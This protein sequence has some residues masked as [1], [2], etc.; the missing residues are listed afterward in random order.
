MITPNQKNHIDSIGRWVLYRLALLLLVL[1]G[2]FCA[3]SMRMLDRRFDSFD[4]E[5]YRQELMRVSAAFD[6]ERLSMALMIGDYARWDD[7]EQFVDDHNADFIRSNFTVESLAYIRITAYVIEDT[8]GLPIS[9]Q[10]LTSDG[11]LVDTPGTLLA[12]L[13]PWLMKEIRSGGVDDTATSLLWLAETP[14][15]FSVAPITDTARRH[16][17]SGY[18]FFLRSLDIA[19]LDKMRKTTAAPFVLT[20]LREG[21]E[22]QP[23][24]RQYLDGSEHHWEA[25]QALADWPAAISVSGPTKLA[26]E[27]FLAHMTL[28]LNV[29][30]LVSASLGGI[31]AILNYRVLS[32]LKAFSQLAER[33]QLTQESGIRWPIRGTDELDNLGRS[34]N[35]LLT[36][37]ESQTSNLRHLADHDSLTGIGNRRLLLA[38]L[39]ALQNR[40]R[41]TGVSVNS[42]LMLLDLDGFKMVNDGLG[43]AAGDHV[44][45]EVA[46]RIAATIRD[47]DTAVRLGGDE[48]AVLLEEADVSEALEFARRL[49]YAF[50]Q[51]ITF[52][53]HSLTIRT[54]GGIAPVT[55][56][57]SPEEVLRNADLA[58]YEAKRLGKGQIATFDIGLLD[59]VARKMQLELA[60]KFALDREQLDV[61]FQPIVDARSGQVTGMEALARWSLDGN[62]IPPG[63]FIAIAE[64]AGLIARLG[65]FVLERVGMALQSLRPCHPDLHCSVNLS[66]AQFQSPDLVTTI[67]ETFER[68]GVPPDAVCLELTESMLARAESAIL[69]VMHQLIRL[70]HQ[71]HLDDF[72]TGYS[73]LDRLRD[74]PFRALKIDRSFIVRLREGDDVM[75][76]NIISM[77]R[78]LG[79][80]TIAEGVEVLAELEQLRLMGCTHIQGYYFARPMPLEDLCNWLASRA[81]PPSPHSNFSS[82]SPSLVIDTVR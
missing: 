60:L 65:Q 35:S 34:L 36:E 39:E 71:F 26:D 13:Q 66:V 82:S 56:T 31:Y 74:L 79:M 42:N 19:Y 30:F 55:A 62:F 32:R 6:Q 75:A 40:S 4:A 43:H 8:D 2:V 16:K 61:W 57:L 70:G 5:Y 38:R 58:M 37:V 29:L 52:G 25:S 23:S 49:L 73:S 1:G 28:F 22:A 47:Y 17:A 44:L 68:F 15:L 76:R 63:E 53:D 50:E 14:Y 51:P 3:L 59:A 72:G 33:Q 46:T 9:S 12:N 64:D 80:E 20:V 11:T 45:R 27:R 21:D 7:A 10:M 41:R 78:E 48:F 24:V 54:S 69:P 67:R 81:A 77:G 18:M